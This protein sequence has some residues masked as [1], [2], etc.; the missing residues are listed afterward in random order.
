MK[1]IFR[2]V[3]LFMLATSVL[4]VD[5]QWFTSGNPIGATDYLGSNSATNTNPVIIKTGTGSA[6]TERM[7]IMGGTSTLVGIGVSNP[8]KTLHVNGQF[9]FD[10][11]ST[12][13][14]GGRCH[15]NRPNAT[16]NQYENF[17]SFNT[18]GNYKFLLGLDNDNTDNFHIFTPSGRVLNILQ[19]GFIGVGLPN[20]ALPQAHMHIYGHVILG[21]VTNGKK[22]KF[23]H[24]PWTDPD[25]FFIIPDKSSDGTDD[26]GKGIR[27]SRANGNFIAMGGSEIRKVVLGSAYAA[28]LNYGTSYMGFNMER[29][30][31]TGYWTKSSDGANNGGSVIWGNVA[32]DLYFSPIPITNG[33][34]TSDMG[35]SDNT[36]AANKTLQIRWNTGLSTA[37]KGQVI[38]GEK[39]IVSGPHADFKLSVDGK[40]VATELYVTNANWADYVFDKNYKLMDLSA[41]ENYIKENKHLPHL[42]SAKEIS[43]NGNNLAETDR[44]LLEKIEEL[45]LYI[46]QQEKKINALETKFNTA[47]Q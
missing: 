44:M 2:P 21:D 29:N 15:L 6:I 32:G 34:T 26:F 9:Q 19:N 13:D 1:T 20:N 47:G 12:G 7:R 39:K 8:L 18:A 11:N 3:L 16:G 10:I 4:T 42:P 22:W 28:A 25:D 45:T 24:Q 14:G 40:L 35:F 31:N 5:A 38:I 37:H 27:I 30:P 41:V 43:D 36:V 33:G 17:L 46:L 23:Y